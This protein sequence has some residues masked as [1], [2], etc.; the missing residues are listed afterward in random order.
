[1]AEAHF[2]YLQQARDRGVEVEVQLG[3]ARLVMERQLAEGEAQKF[4]V[5]I[6]DAF[7]GDAVPTHLLTREA[8]DIYLGH[9]KKGGVLAFHISNWYFDFLPVL[10]GLAEAGDMTLLHFFG[11]RDKEGHA[12][13]T[14]V[15]LSDDRRFLMKA[16]GSRGQWPHREAPTLLWTDD[17]SAILPLVDRDMFLPR[18]PIIPIIKPAE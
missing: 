5:L 7:N 16:S 8:L 1:M 9:M 11:G 2:D 12:G 10:K 4:D 13:S 18:E 14:W 3:D 15:L 17:Y 6:I